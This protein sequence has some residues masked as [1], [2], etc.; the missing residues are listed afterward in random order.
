MQSRDIDLSSFR[1]DIIPNRRVVSGGRKRLQFVAREPRPPIGWYQV[2]RSLLADMNLSG[3]ATEG[4]R[5]EPLKLNGRRPTRIYY[6][7]ELQNLREVP[8]LDKSLS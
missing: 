3:G 2:L 1:I 6:Y 4:N 7:P 8:N 5:F